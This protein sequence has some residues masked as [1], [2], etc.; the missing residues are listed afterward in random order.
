MNEILN[1]QDCAAPATA[2]RAFAAEGGVEL[3]PLAYHLELQSTQALFSVLATIARLGGRIA[4]VHAAG[5]QAVIGL[6]ALPQ[7]VHRVPLLLAQLVEVLAVVASA[8]PDDVEVTGEG[9]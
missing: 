4:F 6:L 8:W 5:T 1:S 7:T 2:F 3:T 9:S